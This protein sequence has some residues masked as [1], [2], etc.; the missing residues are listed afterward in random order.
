[1]PVRVEA[2][3]AFRVPVRV[4]AAVYLVKTPLAGRVIPA[5]LD[6]QCRRMKHC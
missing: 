6:G 3:K 4:E 1:M 2:A 5:N